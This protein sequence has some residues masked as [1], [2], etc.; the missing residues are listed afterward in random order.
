MTVDVTFVDEDDYE[1]GSQVSSN[2]VGPLI[3]G[4]DR[5]PPPNAPSAGMV[6]PKDPW[7][8]PVDPKKFVDAGPVTCLKTVC[9]GLVR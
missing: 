8:R 7:G 1:C 6:H 9:V 3:P 2:R 5:P 4:K